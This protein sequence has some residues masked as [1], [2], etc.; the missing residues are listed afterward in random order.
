MVMKKG[1]VWPSIAAMALLL[2]RVE[3][4]RCA[5]QAPVAATVPTNSATASRP[6][7]SP[8]GK[9]ANSR[10]PEKLDQASADLPRSSVSPAIERF[11]R[12]NARGLPRSLPAP[13][14]TPAVSRLVQPTG[15]QVPTRLPTP[16][17]PSSRAPVRDFAPPF[18]SLEFDFRMK[19]APLEPTD[20]RF[21]I[22]LATALRLSDARPLIVAAAQAGVWVAEAELTRAK[23]LWVP[24]LMFGVDYIRHDGGG[25][26]FNKGIMTAPSVNFFY[27]GAGLYQYVN[28]TDAIF[29]PLVARQVLNARHWDIQSAK[30]DALLQTADAYFLVH[31]YRGMYAGALYTV[32]RGT[33][34]GRADRP[35]EHASWSPGSR[36]TGPGTCWPTSSS[37][38]SSAR[39]EWRVRSADLTQVLRLDPRA[40]VVPLE[41]DHTQVTL[42]DPGRALD[43]LMPIALTNRPEIASRRA[44]IQAAEARIRREK[45]AP[46]LPARHA[47]RLPERRH[48]H[49]GRDLRHSAPTAASTSGSGR[50]DVSIQLM[51]QLE[52]IGIGQPR[53]DQGPA[54]LWSRGPS[55]TFATPRTWWRPT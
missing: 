38:P 37:G 55:S 33:R 42:I 7:V 49:P 1:T 18:S 39:Q 5:A 30:N 54:R 15:R 24:T 20:L 19:P 44:L 47:Q 34:P 14:A 12:Q 25:P 9:P 11:V 48:V 41:H 40:V 46:A 22:N 27:A 6:L 50:D 29:E 32:E 28:L 8:S 17:P 53:A 2:A 26:D 21:P 4:G 3:P 51:W 10:L 52:N 16:L 45:I 13:A 36:S 31:Q 43:D 23:V 35:A